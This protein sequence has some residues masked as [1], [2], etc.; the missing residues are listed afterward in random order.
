MVQD[1]EISKCR[2]CITGGRVLVLSISFA[3]QVGLV[4]SGKSYCTHNSTPHLFLV[5]E[6]NEGLKGGFLVAHGW[7][8]F[9]RYC[10]M[11]Q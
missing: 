6:L 7:S 10:T 11:C 2:N 1:G 9:S 5:K 3:M 4:D 8:E